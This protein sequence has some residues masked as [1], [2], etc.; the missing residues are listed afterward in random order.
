MKELT[1]IQLRDKELRH[2]YEKILRSCSN[3]RLLSRRSILSLLSGMPAPRFFITPYWAS[4]YILRHYK[5]LNINRRKRGMIDDLVENYERLRIEYPYATKCDLY[6]MLVEQPAKSFYM[7]E[8]RIKEI[9]FNY[10]GRN[11]KKK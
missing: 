1:L 6:E 3:T 9:I 4:L 8:Q 2:C 11:G 5:G 7:S 10:T